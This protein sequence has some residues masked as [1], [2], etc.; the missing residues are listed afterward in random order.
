LEALIATAEKARADLE[1]RVSRERTRHLRILARNELALNV[2]AIVMG[3]DSPKFAHDERAAEDWAGL[4][5]DAAA[6]RRPSRETN[7]AAF[8]AMF[9]RGRDEPLI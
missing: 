8:Q 1:R 6:I 2:K 9:A 5:L 7:P 3:S 4:V